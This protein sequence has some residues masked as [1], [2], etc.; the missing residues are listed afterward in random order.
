MYY[1]DLKVIVKV[2]K[3]IYEILQSVGISQGGNVA[4]V[5]L[6]FLMPAAVEKLELEWKKAT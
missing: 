5:L 1:T 4:P 6:L 3:E 2:E